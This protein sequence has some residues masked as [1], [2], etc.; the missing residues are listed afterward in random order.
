[1]SDNPDM[2]PTQPDDRILTTR[3][4][5][6]QLRWW[7]L[8]GLTVAV[9]SAP[10][11]LAIALPLPPLLAVLLLLAG[12]NAVAQMR[13]RGE[14]FG[15]PELAGQLA[16]DLAGMG[17]MLYLTGGATNPLV[18]LMLLP[19]TVAAL[20]LP[21]RWVAGIAALAVGLYSFLMLYSLPLP[22]ADAERATR[23]HLGGMWLTFVVSAVMM[24]W[25]FTRMTASIRDRDAQLA[26]AREDALRDAQVVALGQLAAGAAHELG[27]PLATMNI[28]AGELAQDAR[29]PGDAHEDLVLLRQQIAICKDIVGGLT[30]RAGIE[31]AGEIQRVPVTIW[32]DGLLA[33]WRTLWPQASCIFV[34][35]ENGTTPPHVVVEAT[36][37]Q[38]ITNLLNNAAKI[39]PHGMRLSAVYGDGML[40]ITV[41]DQGPGF[42]EEILQRC[43]AEPM[44]AHAHGSGIGLWLTR[45]AVER[46]GGRMRLENREKGAV[47]TIEL[48]LKPH[49]ADN[50]EKE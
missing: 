48:P 36:L 10:T 17:V 4:R 18:S 5:L 2:S 21:A 23:L 8:A 3:R 16:V 42:P 31:R 15:V 28:L 49:T 32:L 33:R 34:L 47:A 11:F 30:H 37:E 19:V 50:R 45:A 7:L 40:R 29:L 43:G 20:S 25:F 9:L 26:A 27:T 35:E 6:A 41:C 44:P 12:F 38:A 14:D 46:M 22:I 1:M 24:A 13:G 39:A